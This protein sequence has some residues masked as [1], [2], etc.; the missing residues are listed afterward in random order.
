MTILYRI[1]AIDPGI[2]NTG[3]SILDVSKNKLPTIIY[4]STITTNVLIKSLPDIINNYGIRYTKQLVIKNIL[5]EIII[6]FVPNIVVIESS[7]IAKSINAFKSLNELI[8]LVENLVNEFNYNLTKIFKPIFFYKKPPKS[9]K[10]N[11]GLKEL[12]NDKNLIKEALKVYPLDFNGF[13]IN[14]M[15]EH[16]IDAIAI[17]LWIY[18]QLFSPLNFYHVS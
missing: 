15:D 2:D 9:I 10:K 3:I 14:T 12:S 5:N 8:L 1:L 18:N 17:G 4:S 7:F 6:T 16:A 13:D 11:L